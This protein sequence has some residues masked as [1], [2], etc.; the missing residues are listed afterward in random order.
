MK[1]AI[2]YILLGLALAVGCERSYS[3]YKWK[4]YAD[5]RAFLSERAGI[6]L[7]GPS[8]VVGPDGTEIS[9]QQLFD[10]YMHQVIEKSPGYKFKK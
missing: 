1:Y 4:H 7:F 6:Y 9:R 5:E 8:G 10:A 3:A 2:L